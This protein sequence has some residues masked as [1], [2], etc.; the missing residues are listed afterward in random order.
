M[1]STCYNSDVGTYYLLQL[2]DV[3][4]MILF[5]FITENIVEF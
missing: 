5:Y 2:T 1:E 3:I 4:I